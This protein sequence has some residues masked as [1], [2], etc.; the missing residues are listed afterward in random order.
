MIILSHFAS[1]PLQYLSD[2]C[3]HAHTNKTSS[4]E[5]L[6]ALVGE[7]CYLWTETGWLFPPVFVFTLT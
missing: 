4:Y 2:C 6:K 5:M 1:A 3:E 7:F